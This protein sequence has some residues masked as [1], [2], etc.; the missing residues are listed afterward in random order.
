MLVRIREV[1]GYILM[2]VVPFGYGVSDGVWVWGGLELGS[3]EVKY[4][5]GI[6]TATHF[7]IVVYAGGMYGAAS[8]RFRVGLC[9]SSRDCWM[10][11]GVISSTI[12]A[13]VCYWCLLL[14]CCFCLEMQV[15]K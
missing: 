6:Y 5:A 4:Y 12:L 7:S 2:E 3:Y 10:L 14:G 8:S 15:V 11:N 9:C 1:L 13:V